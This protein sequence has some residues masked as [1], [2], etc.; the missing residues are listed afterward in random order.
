MRKEKDSRISVGGY[1]LPLTI[2]PIV[3]WPGAAN[4]DPRSS[5]F[6]AKF[7]DTSKTFAFEM[8]KFKATD[9]VLEMFI[10]ERDIRNNGWIR[11][12][13]RAFQP[14]VIVSFKSQQAGGA[15]RFPCDTFDDWRDN[16]RAIALSLEALRKVD[17]YGVTKRAEQF[18]GW[19]AIP[20]TT[21]PTMTAQAAAQLI[22]DTTFGYFADNILQD[23]P[24]ARKAIRAA[25]NV[26]HPDKQPNGDRTEYDKVEVARR[27]LTA[28]HGVAL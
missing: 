5:P 28:H 16:L 14:G 1:L 8:F 22:E 25:I 9:I 20:A 7:S 24:Y 4:P 26:T 27:V 18:A 11:E 15:V 3:A 19:K 10:R 2:A 21:G 6:R 23:A 17:R 13:A 12:E